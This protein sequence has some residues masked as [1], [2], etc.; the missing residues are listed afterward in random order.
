MMPEKDP[1]RENVYDV[2]NEA[3][4]E[5]NQNENGFFATLVTMFRF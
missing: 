3:G 2:N 4:A 5:D 1:E